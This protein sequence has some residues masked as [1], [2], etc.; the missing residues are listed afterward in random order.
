M[1]ILLTNKL[2][3]SC[4]GPIGNEDTIDKQGVDVDEGTLDKQVVNVSEGLVNEKVVDINESHI[5]EQDIN[6][7]KSFITR[8]HIHQHQWKAKL[9]KPKSMKVPLENKYINVN[10]GLIDNPRKRSQQLWK[11]QIA[12]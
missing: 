9:M 11:S 2:S 5:N 4:E 1:I 6:V 3:K 7:D 10:E 8:Q 12:L